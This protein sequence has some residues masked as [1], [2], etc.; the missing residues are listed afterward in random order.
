MRQRGLAGAAWILLGLALLLQLLALAAPALALPPAL[1]LLAGGLA[2]LALGAALWQERKAGAGE[3]LAREDT[4]APSSAPAPQ[5]NT[6]FLSVVSHELRTPLHTILGYTQLLQ[7]QLAGEAREKLAIIANSST[8]LLALIDDI[9]DFGRGEAF[10]VELHLEAISLHS[11]LAR[12]EAEARILAAQRGNRFAVTLGE[13]LPAAFEADEQRLIQLLQNLIGNALKYTERG[14]VTLGV[15]GDPAAVCE[16]PDGTWHRLRFTVEDTGIGIPAADLAHIF[17]PFA[18]A[19]GKQRQPGAGLGLAIARQLARA[20]GGD[21]SVESEVGQ[22]SRFHVDLPLR[23]APLAAAVGEPA[24]TAAATGYRGRPLTLLVADDIEENRTILREMFTRLGF[25]V[26]TAN[27]GEE[28]LAHCLATSPPVDAALVDQFMPGKD[29]WAFLRAIRSSPQH[30]RLPVFLI[31]AAAPK[32]PSDLPA[33]I[34]FDHKLMKPLRLDQLANLLQQA[35]AFEWAEA[36]ALPTASPP[37]MTFPPADT[38]RDIHDLLALGKVVALQ[39]RARD[40]A[41]EHPHYKAFW[42]RL[43]Q[44]SRAIDLAGLKR[45]L[46][47]A[48]SDRPG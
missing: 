26:L 37:A 17:E 23:A 19:S 25:T 5:A 34:D 18:R 31:S 8:Q 11:L 6:A 36:P 1:P 27:D 16:T 2:F 22:G 3:R 38:L 39:R 30:A 40:L 9:L 47:E 35:L 29:G 14:C 32:R 42:E 15:A 48:A 20:M 45:L 41:H 13:C 33:A 10:S 43:E 7:R 4:E 24:N 46:D 28:A 44:L 12:L 21:I